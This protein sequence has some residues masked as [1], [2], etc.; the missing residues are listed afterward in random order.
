MKIKL[1]KKHLENPF[2]NDEEDNYIIRS[3]RNKS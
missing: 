2:E 1:K 3:I